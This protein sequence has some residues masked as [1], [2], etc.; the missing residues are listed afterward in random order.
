MSE[1][2]PVPTSSSARLA[3]S[4]STRVAKSRSD[5]IAG[6]ATVSVISKIS[7]SG[8]RFVARISDS[9]MWT[10]RRSV[11]EAAERFTL[12]RRP[13]AASLSDSLTTQRSSWRIS[14]KLSAIGMN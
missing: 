3:P 13:A 12:T 14:P 9:I 1:P 10:R 8:S 7:R 2:K 5:S 11:I 4:R 6:V